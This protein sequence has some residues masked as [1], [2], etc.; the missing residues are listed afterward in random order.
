MLKFKCQNLKH[1]GFTLIEIITVVGILLIITATA[2]PAYRNFQKQS[3]LINTTE[4]I[5]NV[6]RLAQSKTLAS[7]Q[8]SQWGI[9][10]LASEYILFKGADYDSRDSS[11]DKNY[12][13]PS[14]VEI[15]E[16]D[17]KGA[18][19]DVV[20]ERI[21]GQTNQFGS[22][23]LRLKANTLETRTIIVESSGQIFSQQIV[24]SDTERIKDSR[25]TH[26]NYAR[27]IDTSIEIL[28]LTFTYDSSS[29]S[30]DIRLIDNI[31]D[32]QIFWE[33]EVNVN[34]EIQKIK[35][36]THNLNDPVFNTDF[37]VHRD[38]RYNN[39]SLKIEISGDSTGDLINYDSAGQTIQ[40]SSIYV[41]EP[42]W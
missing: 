32:N 26:F 21:I 24:P 36:H 5:I 23:S 18:G 2:I 3:D 39:K 7:E 28:T 35:I 42:I 30:E 34:E 17:L 16:V 4:E 10:F 6:L 22:I 37:C 13:V 11:F 12:I 20:F 15:H 25:H 31:K 29:F 1:R 27:Q 41:S 9:H 40:G 33:G 14:L 8:A 38:K 19:F